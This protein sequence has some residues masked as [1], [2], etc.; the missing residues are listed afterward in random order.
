MNDKSLII[1]E[2]KF[3]KHILYSVT[4]FA[5]HLIAHTLDSINLF[6]SFFMH[7]KSWRTN[8]HLSSW[9]GDA[10]ASNFTGTKRNEVHSLLTLAFL[11]KTIQ[12]GVCLLWETSTESCSLSTI[13]VIMKLLLF[14]WRSNFIKGLWNWSLFPLQRGLC[15]RAVFREMTWFSVLVS[16]NLLT[17]C[18]S[19][20]RYFLCLETAGVST[21][22][23]QVGG[24]EALSGSESHWGLTAIQ[25]Q[26]WQSQSHGP[27]SWA[28]TCTKPGLL[29]MP[30]WADSQESRQRVLQRIV[31]IL[32][33][34]LKPVITK[35]GFHTCFSRF[36]FCFFKSMLGVLYWRHYA[37][38]P[39][40]DC[41]VSC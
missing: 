22:A 28:R 26:M 32:K 2:G 36:C 12:I 21:A 11:W 16:Y 30:R 17:N 7:E 5:L 33:Y 8:E 18:P 1:N 34:S 25:N 6:F 19:H 29:R 13:L 9:A 10:T 38:E 35:T 40:S 14:L 4:K 3:G 27:Y 23:V 41:K 15:S 37:T 20:F 24:L 39:Q 31:E